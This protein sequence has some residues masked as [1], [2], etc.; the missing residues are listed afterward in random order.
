MTLGRGAASLLRNGENSQVIELKY[1]DS[2]A[3]V[4]PVARAGARPRKSNVSFE[5]FP[6]K[7][8]EAEA[9]LWQAIRRLE[10][11]GPSFVSV[12]YGAGGSTR[13]RTHH[14]VRRIIEETAMQPAA[15]LT[16]VDASKA[17]MHD[18][19]ADYWMAG[20][21]HIVALRGDPPGAIGGAYTPPANGY[22]N[23]TELVAAITAIAPFEVT[24]GCYPEK[25]PESPSFDHDIDVLKAKIDAGGTRAISQFFF[26]IEAFLRFEDRVRKAGIFIPLVPGIMPVTNFAS[27][28]RLADRCQ[29][30]LP[31]W[32]VRHLEGLDGDPDTRRLVA[33][34][35]A[36]EMCTAL[37]ERGFEDFHF[38]TLNRS[39]LVYAVCRMLGV[40][41]A[42]GQ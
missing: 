30:R 15:H 31:A 24:V 17:E 10:P 23:A 29:T 21:R 39:D 25:H 28:V 16:C 42:S 41:E 33:V 38:Y 32:L 20:V 13:E 37:E 14:T 40:K 22:A 6:P 12:T 3:R 2:P 7:S 34:S 5:F 27:L 19:I 18:V 26:D 11:L 1:P 9:G 36:A 8:D 4:G 35:L